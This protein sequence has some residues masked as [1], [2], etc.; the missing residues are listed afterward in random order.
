[1]QQRHLII[2]QSLSSIALLV[3]LNKTSVFGL[4]LQGEGQHSAVHNHKN[5]C[6]E[7]GDAPAAA[8]EQSSARLLP[9]P[10]HATRGTGYAS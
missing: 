7:G 10:V 3:G 1:M 6:S 9:E 2:K 5:A 4:F 8:V